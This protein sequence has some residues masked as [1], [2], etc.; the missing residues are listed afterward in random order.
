[1]VDTTD[2][3]DEITAKSLATIELRLNRV[4]RSQT[5]RRPSLKRD[6]G[7]LASAVGVPERSK[8]GALSHLTE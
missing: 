6:A 1:M 2:V 7:D 5:K 3:L 4:E 8:K